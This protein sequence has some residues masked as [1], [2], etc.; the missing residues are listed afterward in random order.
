[1]DSAPSPSLEAIA[2]ADMLQQ[3]STQPGNLACQLFDMVAARTRHVGVALG[4]QWR[5]S[6]CL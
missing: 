5:A 6:Y 2:I 1:M 3:L 4:P